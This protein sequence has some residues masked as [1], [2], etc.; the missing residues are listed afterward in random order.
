[1]VRVAD[2]TRNAFINGDLS[3]VM[4][5]RTVITWAENADIFKDIGFA[6][7]LTFLNKCDELERPLVAEFY[8]RCFGQE[9]PES[10]VNVALIL[11]AV[12]RRSG[13]L[14]RD[15]LVSG[16]EHVATA[17]RAQ[18]KEAPTEPFKRAV[19]GC[20]RAIARQPELE[21][22]FAADR[23]ALTPDKA[24]LPEPPRKMSRSRR[25]DRARPR[26]LHGAAARLPRRRP[27]TAGSRPRASRPAP[28]STRSSRRASRRS[29]RGAWPASPAISPRCWRTAITAATIDE[30]TDRADAPIEDA[31]A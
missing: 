11:K 9:L 10:A 27:S 24:R 19:A 26:R 13:R 1:M 8:Q 28:S 2:L 23:P 16:H 17:S 20:L 31:V 30:I 14:A 29:A 21:V 5:P 15:E 6:F 25:G 3:T 12:T 7:R 22:T 18:P 4:S